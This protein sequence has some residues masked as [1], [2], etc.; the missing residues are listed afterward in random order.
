ML[1]SP[2]ILLVDDDPCLRLVLAQLFVA[3]G[4]RVIQLADGRT[5]PEVVAAEQP[6][7]VVLDVQMPHQDGWTTLAELRRKGSTLPVLMLTTF[8]E[9]DHRIRGLQTGADDYVSKGGDLRELLARVQALLRRTTPTEK[10][11]RQL[12]FGSL[13][14]DLDARSA[15]RA[16]EAI[17]FTRIEY[18][19]L[20][21]F[22]QH[23]GRP[24]SRELMLDRVWGYDRL[25][26]TRTIDTHL[27]RLRKK[28]SGTDS[29]T[30][31]LRNVP[32][33]GYVLT[34]DETATTE[35]SAGALV[36]AH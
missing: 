15:E 5:V 10:G 4:Y 14:V 36:A 26:D 6:A 23:L 32:A 24:V 29:A 28:L 22:S 9:V 35:A 2:K 17:A 19:L 16:G 11:P 12:H 7:L 27:W 13:T 30:R 20:E 1:A 18:L 34:C 21:L 25:P 31:W 33:A 3:A 8:G